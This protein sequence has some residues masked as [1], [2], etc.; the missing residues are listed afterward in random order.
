MRRRAP[1]PSRG[2]LALLW[3][4]GLCAC[5][6]SA[7]FAPEPPSWALAP[8]VPEGSA[9]SIGA[10]GS[11]GSPC[12]AGECA[13]KID[14]R[15]YAGDPGAGVQFIQLP[16]QKRSA[17][18]RWGTALNDIEAHLPA[19]YGNAYRDNDKVTHGHETSHGI[20][21]H[22][23][24]HLNT[25]GKRANGFYLLDDQ[26][27]LVVEP[28]LRK[29]QVAPF[30]P[31]A[32]RGSRYGTYVTG[33]VEWDDT[34][35]YLWD[36]WNAYVNGGEVAVDLFSAGLWD[37]GSRDAVAGLLE[38][39]VY[40]LA[41]GM[42]V[43]RH[44]PQYFESNAQFREFLALNTLRAMDLFRAGQAMAPFAR[45]DQTAY[46]ELLRTGPEA[47]PVRAFAARLFGE[48]WARHALFGEALPVDP[49]DPV[50]PVE[51]DPENNPNPPVQPDQPVDPD[52]ENDPLEPE[53]PDEP[54]P[55]PEPEPRPEPQPDNPGELPDFPGDDT[56]ADGV[57]DGADLCSHSPAGQRV[58][59]DGAWLGC[60]AG[61]RR[62]GHPPRPVDPAD[63][64][65]DGIGDAD[66]VCLG[67]PR[68]A[69]VWG[70]GNWKGCAGGQRAN[71]FPNLGAD[72]DADGV[73]D[74]S[75]LCRA[76]PPGRAVWREGAWRGCAG[77]QRRD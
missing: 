66:D 59:T 39:T 27:V 47:Q 76:T 15:Y 5:T 26:A 14:S 3:S 51:P 8:A 19:S 62:D 60:A 12:G 57:A 30:I 24:N 4:T 1:L 63:A 54:R 52:P 35:L 75:D 6:A 49:V 58:W 73:P 53:T 42:A 64:D 2:A 69:R 38:F 68:G 71:N 29:S 11:S 65:A 74:A 21:S 55:E 37:Q 16:E 9:D 77:G 61:E 72:S 70:Q 10:V 18:A 20:H 13:P 31:Q 50:D 17:N 36:E 48:G 28:N 32:L 25:T 33:Q 45:A 34:P 44:D 46:Y 22:I 56:D 23:R 43:E 7:D 67:T 41:V 40:A